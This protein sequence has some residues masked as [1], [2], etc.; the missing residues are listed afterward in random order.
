M[1]GSATALRGAAQRRASALAIL[2]WIAAACGS[3]PSARPSGLAGASAPAPHPIAHPG[4]TATALLTPVAGSD[5]SMAGDAR[6]ASTSS[7]VDLVLQTS[8][9]SGGVA[10]P[11]QILDAGD[12]AAAANA[13]VW[14]EPRGAGIPPLRCTGAASNMGRV[15]YARGLVQSERAWSVGTGDGA[16]LVGRVL[17]VL[18][19]NSG[20]PVS[21]GPIQRGPDLAPA[22]LPPLD[23]GPPE[24]V[25]AA[26]GGVCI[27]RAVASNGVSGCPDEAALVACSAEHCD[28]GAC[29]T[30]CADFGACLAALPD[31][32]TGIFSCAASEACQRCQMDAFSCALAFCPTAITCAPPITP[33]GPCS[34]LEAC[35]ALQGE[36]A[37]NCLNAVQ[38]TAKLGGDPSCFGATM[39]WDIVSHLHVPCAFADG[40]P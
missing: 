16:D 23:E 17:V 9:C 40:Q 13:P 5:I 22:P 27:T 8:G 25:R 34:Q 33:D 30:A 2:L 20:A 4:R 35:C 38:S 31:P 11:V 36:Q 32:C 1:K 39:D 6:F 7:S 3:E 37:P 18:D 29:L 28:L 24:A 14:D 26:I 15:A 21:C 19:P 12:C 10:Y